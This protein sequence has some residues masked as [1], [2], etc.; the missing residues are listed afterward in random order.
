[1]PPAFCTGLCSSPEGSTHTCF[2][3]GE[4]TRKVRQESCASII[5]DNAQLVVTCVRSSRRAASACGETQMRYVHRIGPKD[6]A[7]FKTQGA[8]SDNF[9]GCVP[10]SHRTSFKYKTDAFV[11]LEASRQAAL[12]GGDGG[13]S[14]DKRVPPPLNHISPNHGNV[15]RAE[16]SG[17]F[18]C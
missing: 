18:W 15:F 1:M 5:H 7:N 12:M 8:A 10:R 14:R 17:C 6:V 9:A 2:R 4:T 11:V 16:H 13:G 3:G